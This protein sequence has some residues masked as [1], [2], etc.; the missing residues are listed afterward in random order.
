MKIPFQSGMFFKWWIMGR[1]VRPGT[2][3]AP[4]DSLT[5][6]EFILVALATLAVLF[7]V[8]YLIT[9]LVERRSNR[10]KL[11]DPLSPSAC[12]LLSKS[13]PFYNKQNKRDKI[14][15]ERRVQHYINS[16]LFTAEE[17]YAVT[18]E[19]KVAIAASAT[20]I[21]FR[22]P[23]L[24]NTLFDHI[25]I[26]VQATEER[27]HNMRNSIVIQWSAFK[28]GY[29][30]DNDGKN[31]G[32]KMMALALM[33]DYQMQEK[34]YTIFQ[35]SKYKKWEKA[36]SEEASTFMGGTYLNFA[37]D[38]KLRNTYFAN[39]V[40]YFFELPKALQQKYPR[41]YKATADLLKQDTAR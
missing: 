36:A 25:H 31:E 5:G 27:K 26:L 11:K 37:T 28:E 1:G 12:K 35:E 34:G 14:Q 21:T 23:L 2:T 16:K 20:Q 10:I 33:N 24:S 17:G 3:S 7:F 40:V 41:L 13:S 4:E 32:L 8:Y 18:E 39:A 30:M 6:L 9:K 19:M 29:A 38:N 15:F 22:L